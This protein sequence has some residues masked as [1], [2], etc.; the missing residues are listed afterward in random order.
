M[1]FKNM[2]SIIYKYCHKNDP[3]TTEFINYMKTIWAKNRL[4]RH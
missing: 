2:L 3:E 4:Q 1:V